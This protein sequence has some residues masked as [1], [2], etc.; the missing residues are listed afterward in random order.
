MLFGILELNDYFKPY[1]CTYYDRM[2][3]TVATDTLVAALTKTC[4]EKQVDTELIKKLCSLVR[5]KPLLPYK[6]Q[7]FPDLYP[8]PVEFCPHIHTLFL[9]SR[10]CYPSIHSQTS[11]VL[12]SL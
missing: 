12:S 7:I 3:N 11:Q 9:G 2:S 6:S 4:L 8:E 1:W 5:H 10:Q